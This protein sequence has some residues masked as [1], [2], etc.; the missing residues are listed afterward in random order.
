MKTT[1]ISEQKKS[2]KT[3]FDK[4]PVGYVYMAGDSTGPIAL[5]LRDG[6]AVLLANYFIG[7]EGM[8]TDDLF[9]LA[10]GYKNVSAHKILGKLTE[11]IVQED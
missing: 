1:I 6:E 2:Q 8:P 7:E 9:K 3:P 5:K 4:I 10:D 11:I